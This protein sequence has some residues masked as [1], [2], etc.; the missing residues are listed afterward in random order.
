MRYAKIASTVLMVCCLAMPLA[1]CFFGSFDRNTSY[2]HA[3]YP[4]PPATP[5]TNNC[6]EPSCS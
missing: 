3:T 5:N 6:H 2:G 1:G 4:Y